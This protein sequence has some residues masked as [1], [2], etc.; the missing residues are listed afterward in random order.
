MTITLKSD[1]ISF[2]NNLAS[3]NSVINAEPVYRSV[4]QVYIDT[5]VTAYTITDI[6]INTS[7]FLYLTDIRSTA[8]SAFLRYRASTDNGTTW[9][10]YIILSAT[11]N[12]STSGVWGSFSRLVR[13]NTISNYMQGSCI[14]T[15]NSTSGSLTIYP[16][17]VNNNFIPANANAIEISFSTST[18]KAGSTGTWN[19][20]FM[21]TRRDII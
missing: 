1:H 6:P 20:I 12:W 4:I 7:F 19:Q 9:G 16:E 11:A 14:Q 3:A 15:G 10:S 2:N 21:Y 8:T 17:T 18:I 5:A 13:Q